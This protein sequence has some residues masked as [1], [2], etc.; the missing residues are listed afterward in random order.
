M[1]L[2]FLC[3][4]LAHISEYRDFSARCVGQYIDGC[5]HGNRICIVAVVDDRNAIFV[6]QITSAAD[7]LH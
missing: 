7:R 6:D 5:F 1:K 3:A 4:K 2:F